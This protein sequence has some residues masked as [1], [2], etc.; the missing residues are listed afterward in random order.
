MA[1]NSAK[2]LVIEDEKDIRDSYLDMF[3]HFGYD[4]ETAPNGREGLSKIVKQDYDI[5]VTDLYM[6]E[7]D[8][9]EVLNFIKKS[10]PYTEVI[11]ITGFATLDNAI[12]AMKVGAYDYFTKP[13]DID[14]VRIVLSKCV[15][16]LRAKRENEELKSLNERLREINEMKDKFITITNHELRTPLT[17]LKGYLELID[18]YLQD[19][20]NKDLNDAFAVVSETMKELVCIIEDMHDVSNFNHAKKKL[21]LTDIDLKKMLAVIYKEMK[22]LFD[23]RKIELDLNCD[24]PGVRVRGDYDRIKRSIRELLQNALKFTP[25]GGRVQ[26]QYMVNEN[27]KKASVKVSDTGIGIPADKQNLVFEPFYEIQDAMNHMTSKTE[28]LGGGI[29][30]GLTLA[31]DVFESHEG[32]ILLESEVGKGST[33]TV[34]IP[35]SELIDPNLN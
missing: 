23:D 16:Q 24:S 15:Q 9:L 30:L 25:E 17:V 5:V 33:F 11:V 3:Q 10:K 19:S 7:V 14:H 32:T 12:K 31:R 22:V 6:P 4:V 26:L 2:I 20:N 28:F 21:N 1:G 8:G 34:V 29:G 35:Y 13:V 18:Y 27:N